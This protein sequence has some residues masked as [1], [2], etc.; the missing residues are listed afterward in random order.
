MSCH[1]LFTS[2]SDKV[3]RIAA[4][5]VLAGV[6]DLMVS[7]NRTLVM[8]IQSA[9]YVDLVSPGTHVSVPCGQLWAEPFPA[10]RSN[11]DTRH[12]ALNDGLLLAFGVS[13]V[14][15]GITMTEPTRVVLATPAAPAPLAELFTTREL[16]SS[17]R[18]FGETRWLYD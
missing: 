17:A 4:S 14:N 16:A 15:R 18:T 9:M 1:V 13:F 8:L 6:M 5:L 11:I 2:Q 10:S 3:R 12:D 7:R